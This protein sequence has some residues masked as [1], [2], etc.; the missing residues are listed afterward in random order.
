MIPASPG[1]WT[2]TGTERLPRSARLR[3]SRDIRALFR[4][5]RRTRTASL[6][7]LV[8]ASDGARARVGWVVP[9]LGRRI[10]DRNKLKRR[11]REIGRKRV[12]VCLREAG[13]AADVL[14]RARTPAYRASYGQLEAEVMAVVEGACSERR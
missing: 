6:E 7:V 12:L 3:S 10:V 14:V 13:L 5:G 1:E 11:L 2:G 4:R 8:L 9:K